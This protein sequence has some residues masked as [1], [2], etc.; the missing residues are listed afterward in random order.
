MSAPSTAHGQTNYK[1]DWDSVRAE[2]AA[3]NPDYDVPDAESGY[4]VVCDTG[5]VRPV[6]NSCVLHNA[7]HA[8][9]RSMTES[10]STS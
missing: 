7:V 9:C 3:A 10:T 5:Q 8:Q 6:K 1:R 4:L 2:L